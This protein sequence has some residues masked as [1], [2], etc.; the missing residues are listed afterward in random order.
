MITEFLVF[1]RKQSRNEV[2]MSVMRGSH[3]NS[4]KNLVSGKNKKPGAKKTEMLLTEKTRESLRSMGNGSM[5]AGVEKVAETIEAEMNINKFFTRMPIAAK[6]K[7]MMESLLE[8]PDLLGLEV[9]Q[10][11][12]RDLIDEIE[13]L[14]LQQDFEESD[15]ELGKLSGDAWIV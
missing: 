5:T 13:S 8:S 11:T 1:S 14:G 7:L 3:E 15:I 12:I 9:T 10:C 6:V 4:K 2:F